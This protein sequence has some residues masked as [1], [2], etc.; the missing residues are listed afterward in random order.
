MFSRDPW[1]ESLVNDFSIWLVDEGRISRLRTKA[2][3]DTNATI[4]NRQTHSAQIWKPL[5]SNHSFP[6][7][8]MLREIS[9][10]FGRYLANSRDRSIQMVFN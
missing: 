1:L 8:R 2:T 7:V 10:K 9:D 6:L 5:N 4:S 3:L